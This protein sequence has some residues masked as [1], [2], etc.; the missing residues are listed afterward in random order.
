MDQE[1]HMLRHDDEGQQAELVTF[2]RSVQR[3]AEQFA[4]AIIDEKLSTLVTRERQLVDVTG[5]VEMTN[6]L[7]VRSWVAH[8]PLPLNRKS[9]GALLGKPAVASD[10]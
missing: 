9:S 6:P 5:F 8:V 7:S 1:M 2:D 3:L 10:L 4:N